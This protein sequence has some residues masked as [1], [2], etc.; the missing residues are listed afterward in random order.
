MT[1]LNKINETSLPPSLPESINPEL[2][3]KESRAELNHQ[4]VTVKWYQCP[5]KRW[6]LAGKIMTAASVVFAQV[7]I[8]ALISASF[9]W[10]VT[11]VLGVSAVALFSA[12]FYLITKHYWKDPYYSNSCRYEYQDSPIENTLLR[13]G[14]K[15]YDIFTEDELTARFTEQWKEAREKGK[16]SAQFKRLNMR[17]GFLMKRYPFLSQA[18]ADILIADIQK[19]GITSKEELEKAYVFNLE[20]SHLPS[21]V[22]ENIEDFLVKEVDSEDLAQ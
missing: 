14:D 11:A 15:V 10:V 22:K 12:G 5:H 6:Q 17:Y 4:S 3:V 21:L 18:I 7:A 19:D 1:E 2:G 9:P 13:F 8:S 16:K 20:K